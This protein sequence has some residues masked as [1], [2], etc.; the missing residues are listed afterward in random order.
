MRG[1]RSRTVLVVAAAAVLALGV[2]GS[3]VA[4]SHAPSA[5]QLPHYFTIACHFS[6]NA[7][8]D[9]IVYPGKPH[10]SHEHTFL[11]NVSTNA[12]STPASLGKRGTTC[13]HSGDRSA[14]W[15]PTL[16]ADGR[17]VQPSGATVY[18]RRITKAPVQAFPAGLV[19]IAGNSHAVTPQSKSVTR[20]LCDVVK[21]SFYGPRATSSVPMGPLG[22]S[23][24]GGVPQC[25]ASTSLELE[26]NFPNCS[27][28]Q[29]DSSNHQ[30]HMAYSVAGKC[31]ASHPIAVP[32]I[33]IVMR[34]PAVS[35]GEVF[36][37]SGGVDSGHADFM[38]GWNARAL[39]SVV[40]DCL[41][42]KIACG[43][44]SEPLSLR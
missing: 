5:A 12:F 9:P 18:Y 39:A 44:P 37:A 14:Y 17:A 11:G 1:G 33:S 35:G 6:H 43:Y 13:N 15:V 24:P 23:A 27:N 30:T 10:R 26:V 28:G 7:P 21:S 40:D 25:P 16:Y 3:S 34:Y 8:D 2:A 22:Q 38:D 20:W 4:A 41:N 32:E 29:L 42:A 31:P 36:L 19:M